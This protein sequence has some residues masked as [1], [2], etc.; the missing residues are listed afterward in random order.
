MSRALV[1]KVTPKIIKKPLVNAPKTAFAQS[2]DDLQNVLN[3]IPDQPS[4]KLMTFDELKNKATKGKGPSKRSNTYK[5]LGDKLNAAQN[6]LKNATL[7][8]VENA[9]GPEAYKKAF[10]TQLDELNT[11]IEAYQKHHKGKKANAVAPLLNE[12]KAIRGE[13]AGTLA[14]LDGAK[15]HGFQNDASIETVTDFRTIDD[16]LNKALGASTFKTKTLADL[17]KKGG[18][19]EIEK[20]ILSELDTLEKS[21]GTANVG[22]TNGPDILAGIKRIKTGLKATLD[23]L[24][25]QA[26][27]GL[28]ADMGIATAAA[29]VKGGIKP[30]QLKGVCLKHCNFADFNTD[31]EVPP[32]PKQA[33]SG[34]CSKVL[35]INYADG[36]RI[37]KEEKT[38]DTSG[39][40]GAVAPT[41][42]GIDKLNDPRYGNRNVASGLVGELIGS[43]VMVKSSFALTK[44]EDGKSTDVGLLMDQAPGQSLQRA[45]L[46]IDRLAYD[47][48]CEPD[49]YLEKLKEAKIPLPWEGEL[50]P[51]AIASLQKQLIE[52]EVCD[53]LTGQVDR[54]SGNYMIEVKGD[55]VTV[56]GIDNDFAFGSK[57]EGGIP[58]NS[59][60]F[61][62]IKNMPKLMGKEMADKIQGL[63]FDRDFAPQYDGLLIA[64]E[65]KA[66]KERFEA[67]QQ[68]VA[69]LVQTNCV[70]T[71]WET[72]RSAD[73]K[74]A[75]EYLKGGSMFDRDIQP[76]LDVMANASKPAT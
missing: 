70:V 76:M 40:R 7:E 57:N 26:G 52:L 47:D 50:S 4:L 74:T 18:R 6:T 1:R 25:G 35:K 59:R 43:S 3:G 34:M 71:D 15:K 8:G 17:T 46:Y 20:A 24:A 5:A 37:F 67:L 30:E 16:A 22:G 28:P 45:H 72:W 44:S 39:Y 9:G 58:L 54:H 63:D 48:E 62:T 23:D 29:L 75:T 51:K 31:T 36:P 11:A 19:D 42:I 53:L 21:L 27:A 41:Y 38:S 65:I 60:A 2:V 55:Q 69:T 68:H 64:T 14:A 49:E 13:M 56:K 33:G 32:P 73:N 61:H 10:D 66:A 12:V